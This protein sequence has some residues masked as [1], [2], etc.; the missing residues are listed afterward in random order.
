MAST[1]TPPQ[2]K[3]AAG[4]PA[5]GSYKATW[6]GKRA[7]ETPA[8]PTML[9]TARGWDLATVGAA[10]APHDA[11]TATPIRNATRP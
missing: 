10:T 2:K 11:P 9:W 6:N 5:A 1:I 3:P 4:A 8:P 7:I